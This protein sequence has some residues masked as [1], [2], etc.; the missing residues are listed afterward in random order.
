M[1]SNSASNMGPQRVSTLGNTAPVSNNNRGR[2]R[3]RGHG[4]GGRGRDGRGR[5][6]PGRESTAIQTASQAPA[7]TTHG[8]TPAP[9][10]VNQDPEHSNTSAEQSVATSEVPEALSVLCHQTVEVPAVPE[11]SK[12]SDDDFK[13]AEESFAVMKLAPAT[14]LAQKS[15]V[16]EKQPKTR[17]P[18]AWRLGA[19]AVGGNDFFAPT[20]STA[21]ASQ[22]Q[23]TAA[24]AADCV[25]KQLTAKQM[26]EWASSGRILNKAEP[27]FDSNGFLNPHWKPQPCK[28]SHEGILHSKWNP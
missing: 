3:S 14:Q 16:E 11:P 18:N 22:Q 19:L 25:P 10:P 20:A 27:L 21:E 28:E 4:R 15:I 26:A 6:V 5:G 1:L 23:S 9:T 13:D 7:S 17:S 12:S 24:A 2:G 8:D